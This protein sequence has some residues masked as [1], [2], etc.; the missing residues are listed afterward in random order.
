MQQKWIQDL[1]ALC[2]GSKDDEL[3]GKAQ[4]LEHQYFMA[5]KPDLRT[6]TLYESFIHTKTRSA[7]TK[8]I[9]ILP[10]AQPLPEEYD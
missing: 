10:V 4:E 6:L 5:M 1:T 3:Q 9:G 7:Y 8:A 2:N